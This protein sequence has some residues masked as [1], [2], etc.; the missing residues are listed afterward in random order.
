MSDVS[1]PHGEACNQNNTLKDATE[2][3]WVH[4]PSQT[5]AT[6]STPHYHHELTQNQACG[7]NEET[8]DEDDSDEHPK[9]KR[10]VN[11]AYLTMCLFTVSPDLPLFYCP[12][13]LS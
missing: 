4:S 9:C 2:I 6:S 10:K 7:D 5:T 1:K 11:A 12:T 3:E 8:T 13:P